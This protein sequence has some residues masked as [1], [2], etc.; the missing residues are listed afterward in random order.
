MDSF[1]YLRV[2]EKENVEKESSVKKF[3]TIFED[4]AQRGKP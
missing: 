3:V 2:L 1:K 4:K